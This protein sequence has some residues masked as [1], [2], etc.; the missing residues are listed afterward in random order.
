M[1]FVW[2]EDVRGKFGPV[3]PDRVAYLRENV[4]GKTCVVFG[5]MPGGF[6]EVAV[7]GSM[8]EVAA[9][10]EGD[11]LQAMGIALTEALAEPPQQRRRRAKG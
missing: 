1:K 6:D 8:K 4:E 2:L 10:L 9:L 7:N 5:A 11:G 3:N